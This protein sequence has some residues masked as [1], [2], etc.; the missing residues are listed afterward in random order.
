MVA[1]MRIGHALAGHQ[2]DIPGLIWSDDRLISSEIDNTSRFME[3]AEA[4]YRKL[5]RYRDP[6][7]GEVELAQNAM[8]LVDD[9]RAD[10]GPAN[11][12]SHALDPARITRYKQRAL[13]PAYG[14]TAIPEY[15]EGAWADAAFIE[16]QSDLAPEIAI[17]V[18]RHT[19]I[20]GDAL[21]FA[22]RLRC[23]W[24]NSASYRQTDWYRFQEAVKSHLAECW[25]VLT[26]RLP[27]LVGLRDV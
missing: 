2:P 23:N 26:N 3:A 12:N 4:L 13:T 11:R 20:A 7:V 1:L 16:Q 8:A 19:G 15:R 17:F 21:A 10:I 14:R 24:K 27:E 6:G 9:L 5:A 22:T 25:G 18:E